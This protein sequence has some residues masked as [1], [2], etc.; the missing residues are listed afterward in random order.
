MICSKAKEACVAIMR[1]LLV[2]G[3][4]TESQRSSKKF[5]IVELYWDGRTDGHKV[6]V[7][8]WEDYWEPWLE[9]G[10]GI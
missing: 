2:P 7:R 1:D 5:D 4:K 3:S 8:R 10:C 9:G 6:F